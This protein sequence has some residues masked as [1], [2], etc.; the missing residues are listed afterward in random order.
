MKLD[1]IEN[2]VELIPAKRAKKQAQDEYKKN[3][4]KHN[5]KIK[6]LDDKNRLFMIEA[7]AGIVLLIVLIV[8]AI[9]LLVKK[10]SK[11]EEMTSQSSYEESAN[12]NTDEIVTDDYGKTDTNPNL[13]I[14]K[15]DS[16]SDSEDTKPLD[17]TESNKKESVTGELSQTYV[18]GKM[19]EYTADDYQLP[20]I[21]AYWD[22]YQLDAVEDLIRLERVRTIS[23]ALKG[24]NDFYYYGNT[25][26][27][28][29]AD[30]TGLAVYANDTYYFGE[31]S[32][33]Q[34]HGKG[35]WLRIFPDAPGIVNGVKGV[36]EHQYSG[37]WSDDY[38]NGEGQ[39]HFD[40][41]SI[42]TKNE[43][44]ISNAIGIFK[45]GYYNGDMYLMTIDSNMNTTDWYGSAQMGSFK[46]LNSKKNNL[47]KY[48]IWEI[49]DGFSTDEQ[50][51]CRW[52]LAKDNVDYGIAG[53]KK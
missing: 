45:N 12:I 29:Q 14:A 43:Y 52:I 41:E 36:T 8:I 49:G 2:E 28:G 27:K 22:E 19:L 11:K 30:G 38:P 53:L 42:E 9:V 10:D 18:A 17:L 13:D 35:M 50:D 23:A 5:D 32:N 21:Y 1:E 25:N 15:E 7:I 31:W 20:E 3:A 6:V 37:M 48:P 40:F 33:G 4:E 46:A 44:V 39:E 47:G 51:G 34:R 24:S 26:A 16:K